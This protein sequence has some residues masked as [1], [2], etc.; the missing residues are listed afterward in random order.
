[1][2]NSLGVA[3]ATQS[4]R[5]HPRGS[6]FS[7]SQAALKCIHHPAYLRSTS[8]SAD[9]LGIL[10]NPSSRLSS[11]QSAFLISYCQQRRSTSILASLS[12]NLKAYGKKIR[13]GRGPS[14]GK[15]KTAGRG[16]S[17]QKKHGKVPVGFEGGQPPLYIVK[18]KRGFENVFVP[19]PVL[20]SSIRWGSTNL[21][22]VKIYAG[23]VARQRRSNTELGGSRPLGLFEA[24][25]RQGTSRFE[26]YTWHQGWSQASCSSWSLPFISTRHRPAPQS[27]TDYYLSYFFTGR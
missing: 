27:I 15:G 10:R 11:L 16:A 9:R 22:S 7:T 19:L 8:P 1:M 26:V 4:L 20:A 24:H 18:G 25:H 13:R 14:S 2:A 6:V 3:R 17:G 12:D 23:D 5:M 21:N